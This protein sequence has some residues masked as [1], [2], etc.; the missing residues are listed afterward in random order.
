MA[1]SWSEKYTIIIM[2]K[3]ILTVNEP[4]MNIHRIIYTG[5]RR[6]LAQKILDRY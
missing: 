2:Y 3:N 4:A 1:A 6:N 5:P